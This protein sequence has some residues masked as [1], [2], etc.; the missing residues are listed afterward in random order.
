[1]SPLTSTSK[2]SGLFL[3]I[4]HMFWQSIGMHTSVYHKQLPCLEP[5]N[6][7]LTIKLSVRKTSKFWPEE[8]ERERISPSLCPPPTHSEHGLQFTVSIWLHPPS[9]HWFFL[10]FS[11]Y[12]DPFL[13]SSS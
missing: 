8:I 6:L 11:L 9:S 7:C 3:G 1:M 12:F 4:H 2:L 10:C 13:I 5:N